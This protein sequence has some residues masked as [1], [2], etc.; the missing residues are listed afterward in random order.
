M[1]SLCNLVIILMIIIV[2]FF[3]FYFYR[4][5]ATKKIGIKRYLELM[6]IGEDLKEEIHKFLAKKT[7]INFTFIDLGIGEKNDKIKCEWLSKEIKIENKSRFSSEII[8]NNEGKEINYINSSIKQKIQLVKEEIKK[9]FIIEI[10]LHQ[11]NNYYIITNMQKNQAYSLDTVYYS[12]FK[13]LIPKKLHLHQEELK[14][15]DYGIENMRRI[16]IVNLEKYSLIKF[17]N[18]I[19]NLNINENTIIFKS[20]NG[21][22]FLNIRIK[23]I[24]H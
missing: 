14:L 4:Y 5:L 12:Q 8:T 23:S 9:E 13:D 3:L 7:V 2:L 1:I 16:C 17:I 15:D 21:D 20:Q 19:T 10:Y 11:N 18:S 6:N 22:I 24:I